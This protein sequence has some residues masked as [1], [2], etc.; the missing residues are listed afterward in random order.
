MKRN[1]NESFFLK[2]GFAFQLRFLSSK[3]KLIN[4]LQ[5]RELEVNLL[6]LIIPR[7]DTAIQQAT[8]I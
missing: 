8:Q 5:I 4:R 6:N 7:D 1:N 3:Q 2:N